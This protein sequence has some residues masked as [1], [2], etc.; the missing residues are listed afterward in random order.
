[1]NHLSLIAG[2]AILSASPL[3]AQ[4]AASDSAAL[5]AATPAV[6]A[7]T[8]E[9][10][11]AT[12]ELAK[13]SPEFRSYLRL[14]A[15]DI[16]E[17]AMVAVSTSKITNLGEIMQHQ[18]LF[19]QIVIKNLKSIST[20]SLKGE[21]KDFVDEVSQLVP[22]LYAIYQATDKSDR[23]ALKKLEMQVM[24]PVMMLSQKYPTVV[25]YFNRLDAANQ[26]I[27]LEKLRGIAQKKHSNIKAQ[28]AEEEIKAVI[29]MCAQIPA[30]IR[31]NEI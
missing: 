7:T 9:L 17:E 30:M 22:K 29:E 10:I 3:L 26:F 11:V 2:L 6:S 18:D 8:P 4:A 16:L 12:P 19:A 27:D 24:M 31:S 25:S 14:L 15:A 13:P 20:E 1:M 5:T 28:S 23:E 21:E